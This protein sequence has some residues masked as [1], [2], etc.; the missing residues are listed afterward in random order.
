MKLTVMELKNWLA[1]KSLDVNGRKADLVDRV[2]GFF[3][4]L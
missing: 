3:E 1:A 2:D 4:T